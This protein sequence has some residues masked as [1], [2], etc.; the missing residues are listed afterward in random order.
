MGEL[1]KKRM[2]DIIGHILDALLFKLL[3][4]SLV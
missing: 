1:K 3:K 2:L 4:F